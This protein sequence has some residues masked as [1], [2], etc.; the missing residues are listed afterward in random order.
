MGSENPSPQNPG[1]KIMTFRPTLEE[2]RDFGKY[3]AYI[4]SQGAHRAGLAKVIPPKEWKP[5]KTYDDIDDM[6]IPAPIQQVVT[7]QS[8]LFTQYNIQKK[9]MTVGE[10]RRLA[11]SEKYCTPR[12]QDF[13]DLERKY[14][15]NLTFV[16]PIY[17]ADISG[18]LYDADV[19]EWNIGNLNTLLDMVE[20]ECGIIIEGV[21]TPYLYFG[22]WKTTFA[23]HTE[24]MDLYSI[25]YLHFG[26]PKSW[27]AI[28]PEHGKRLERLAKG[29]FPGS[30]QGCDAFLRHK[31]TLISPS[32]L[33]KYGIP[34][35]RITQEAGEFMITFPYGYH[36]GFNHG[37]N[38]A[39]STNFATLRWIDYGKMA[40]QC[41]CRKDMVKISMDVFVRVLQP[42][43]YDLWKQ[44]KDIAV[45]DHM[46]PTALTSPELDAWNETKA[47]L[48]AKLLRRIGD[49]EEDN[50]HRLFFYV[51]SHFCTSRSHRK[52][53]QPRRHKTEDQK[54]LG[55]V[56][57]IETA[58]EDVKVKE[59]LKRGTDLE[60]EERSKVIEGGEGDCKVKARPP[61][62]KSERKKKHLFHQ[63]QHHLQAPQP[64][65]Q[66]QPPPLPP[67]PAPQQQLAGDEAPA[68]RP[69]APPAVPMSSSAEKS[70]PPAPLNII[71]PSEAPLEEDDFKPR[72][73]IPML[74]V[75]PQTKKV[76]FDKERM[77]CQQ[78]F[79]QF[80]TQK[81]PSWREQAVPMEIPVK[82]EE[83]AE[84]ENTE[85]ATETASAFSKMKMEIKK[86]RRH[87]LGKPPTR[88]PLSVVKQE[89]SS[90]E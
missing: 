57:A 64:P 68:P 88:S 4:E 76:V 69:P 66:Q 86:S 22:M 54:S 34:F 65:L 44:G 35:D 12:H 13:E 53:S 84:A 31:M 58:L 6:V 56:M 25:N 32:I 83:N 42:E 67:P 85:V 43:R 79:E 62:V 9:P 90:D 75:V 51:K 29:F 87:P 1:C 89:T 74:Y 77:S 27:Y 48:K 70:L 18:S 26:E 41:T 63:H 46:K 36:A 39:E 81:S 5:R 28:P 40:T 71:Q 61:K 52:R 7:G 21:N 8:G 50:K 19:E 60:E 59:E 11:N 16:S 14:W 15:K 82:E 37:F 33:K 45:L 20:H 23:W 30:S 78:A 3:I 17:G 2:F 72:P 24:D 80:A 49:E 47:E 10:Y 55:D 38:C 73:I